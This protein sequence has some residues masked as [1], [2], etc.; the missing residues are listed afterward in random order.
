MLGNSPKVTDKPLPKIIYD[1]LNIKLEQ[2]IQE[3]LN[4]FL[5]KIKS[6]KVTGL[7]EIPPKNGR[8]GNSMTYCSYS[9]TLYI[10][11]T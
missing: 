2:F 9:A 6:R 10:T 3:E 8:Q 4:I 7:D 5:T 11:G 1:Q